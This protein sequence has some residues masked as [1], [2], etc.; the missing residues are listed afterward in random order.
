MG[1]YIRASIIA[2]LVLGFV[3]YVVL[4]SAPRDFPKQLLLPV[5]S[6]ETGQ[7]IAEALTI[8]HAV[9]SQFLFRVLLRLYGGQTH[10]KTGTYYFAEPTNAFAIAWR[11]RIGNFNIEPVKVTVP[12]G[13][14]SE[15]IAAILA[16]SLPTFDKQTFLYVAKPQE[17]YLFP[18]T[19][20]FYPGESMTDIVKTMR[21]NFNSQVAAPRVQQAITSSNQSFANI[22]TMASLIE[23]E[24][25][26]TQNRLIISGI[27][28]KRLSMGMPLQVDVDRATYATVGLPA[29]PIANP[30]LDAIIAAATPTSTPYLYYISDKQGNFHY[31][32]TY[33]QQLANEKKYLH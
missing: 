9:R 10:I 22:I 25:P 21:D 30:G 17:G 20:F 33:A 4:F 23:K 32:Q 6:G 16:Q 14:D 19:Y 26:D 2:G 7:D 8:D 24:A 11:L 18:D 3:L 31:S 28:W 5:H 29:V 12:E 15:E 13:L 1:L 27:L